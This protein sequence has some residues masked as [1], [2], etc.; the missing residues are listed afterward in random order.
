MANDQENKLRNILNG[1]KLEPFI[2][3]IRFPKYKNLL[4]NTVIEF[5]YPITALVGSNGTNKSSILRALYGSPESNNLGSFWFSTTIDPIKETGD[6]PSCFIYGYMNDQEKK[7]V[8]VLKTRV[9]K[10]DDPDYW[11]T[12]RPLRIYEMVAPEKLDENQAIPEGRSKTRWN[13][14]KK[15]V[16]YI[17]FRAALSAYD[18][19]FYHGELR[20][21][22]NTE[23]NKKDFIRARAPHLKRVIDEGLTS[24]TYRQRERVVNKDVQT[25]SNDEILSISRILGKNY[26]EIKLVRHTF[27]NCDAFTCQMSSSGLKYTEAFAGS[28]EFAVVKIVISVMRAEMHSLILLDEPEVSLHPGAQDRLID[29]LE[30]CVIKNK[31]QIVISTHSTAIVRKLPTDAI[32]VLSMDANSQKVVL[33][34]Q[35]ALPEEAFFHLGE[36]ISNKITILVEDVLAAK[37]VEMALKPAGEANANLFNIIYYPGGAETLWAHYLPIYASEKRKRLFVLFDGDKRPTEE[38]A[39]P[40]TISSADVEKLQIEIKRVSSVDIK[41]YADGGKHGGNTDQQNKMREEFMTW[42]RNHVSYLP[43]NHTPE[44]FIWESMESN[45]KTQSIAGNDAKEKFKNLTRMELGLPHNANLNSEDILATQRR[46]LATIDP[47][48]T[49]MKDLKNRLLEFANLA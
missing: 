13:A 21:K 38:M 36:P 10:D 1:R 19:F 16:E 15:N 14:I 20:L 6:R 2:K 24:F 29:F 17:D 11:E 45:T 3:H 35:S 31:H 18:K 12:S 7:I 48:N 44:A 49:Y 25:L 23:K 37:I 22:P 27:F 32:K 26:E 47:N 33:L 34:N 9:K 46:R 40:K 41:F 28:G 42:V 4:E 5:T 8:E 43:G 39:D 30:E